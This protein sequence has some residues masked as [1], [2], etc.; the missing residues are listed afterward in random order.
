MKTLG[1]FLAVWTSFIFLQLVENCV[2]LLRNLSY[3]VHRE[4]P[5][6]ERYAESAPLNQGPAPANKGGCFGSR[7][8]KGECQTVIA[9]ESCTVSRR[10]AVEWLVAAGGFE[11]VGGGS[12]CRCF[13]HSTTVSLFFLSSLLPLTFPHLSSRPPSLPPFS[14][15]CLDEWFSKGKSS[16][17][18]VWNHDHSVIAHFTNTE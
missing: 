18:G 14:L 2:C 7:K 12:T 15:L 17:P 1:I 9:A 3:Q 10:Y 4:A 5:G 11:L 6:S 13:S 8:G 16:L